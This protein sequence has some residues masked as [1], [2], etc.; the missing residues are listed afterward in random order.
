MEIHLLS[1]FLISN[2][3][4]EDRITRNSYLNTCERWRISIDCF[5]FSVGM[6]SSRICSLPASII[7]LRRAAIRPLLKSIN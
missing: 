7:I 5:L 1:S 3:K 6:F 2:R 4:S